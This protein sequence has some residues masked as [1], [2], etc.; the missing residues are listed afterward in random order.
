MKAVTTIQMTLEEDR[1]IAHLKEELGLSSKKEVVREGLRALQG[2]LK[3]HKR[4]RQLRNASLSVRKQSERTNREW[5][6]LS[7]ALKLP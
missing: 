1:E 2:I 4:R 5:S 7:P 6:L 3:D